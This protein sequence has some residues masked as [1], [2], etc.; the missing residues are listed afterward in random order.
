MSGTHTWGRKR[1]LGGVA[2]ALLAAACAPDGLI[3]QEQRGRSIPAPTTRLHATTGHTQPG[4]GGSVAD[5]T[6]ELTEETDIV[7]LPVGED[8]FV[9]LLA[10]QTSLSTEV[11]DLS[12]RTSIDVASIGDARLRW[13]VQRF[14]QCNELRAS[15][16]YVDTVDQAGIHAG[17]VWLSTEWEPGDRLRLSVEARRTLPDREGRAEFKVNS[18]DSFVEV[19]LAVPRLDSEEVEARSSSPGSLRNAFSLTQRIPGTDSTTLPG[20]EFRWNNQRTLWWNSHAGRWDTIM[21]TA[22]PPADQ[23]SDWW[24]WTD[25]AGDIRP[26]QEIT[27]RPSS[28]SVH[29]D[30][31]CRELS[32]FFSRDAFGTSRFYAFRYDVASDRYLPIAGRQAVA[33]DLRGSRRVTTTKSPKGH[34]WAGVNHEEAVRVARST[35]GGATWADPVVLKATA[36]RGDTEWVSFHIGDRTYLGLAATEDGAAEDARVHFLL[37]D[38]GA[39]DW[40]DPAAWTDETELLPP[41]HSVERADDELSA[42]AHDGQVFIVIETELIGSRSEGIP[43]LVIYRRS[44]SGVWTKH[45][46]NEYGAEWG[47]DLKRPVLAV[48]PV[49]GMLYVGASRSDRT[50]AYVLRSAITDLD[51]WERH[52]AFAVDDPAEQ[53]LYN[54]RLPAQ[55]DVGST[56]LPVLVVEEHSGQMWRQVITSP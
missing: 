9:E 36:I 26:A 10:W 48:D 24:L 16:A 46:V 53:A 54:V 17:R 3:E 52:L 4:T 27:Y 12:I 38:Q 15:S 32:V 45:V 7:A 25:V 13:R 49:E 50:A 33:T 23:V 6:A 29:W 42:V 39:E 18:P 19:A 51:R 47:D 34:L 28:P 55:V 41:H 40:S 31:D 5:L 56:G 22:H 8:T 20:G 11:V 43:Q 37:I 1:A 14:D 44:S 35:D 21:P 2:F 30:D